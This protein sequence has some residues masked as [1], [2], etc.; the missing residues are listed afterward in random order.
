MFAKTGF[1]KLIYIRQNPKETSCHG[2]IKFRDLWFSS[3]DDG[4]HKVESMT[5]IRSAQS[6]FVFQNDQHAHKFFNESCVFCRVD[7]KF[8]SSK[9]TK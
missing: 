8:E 4:S 2:T 3:F 7:D 1:E 6:A 5:I 9:P